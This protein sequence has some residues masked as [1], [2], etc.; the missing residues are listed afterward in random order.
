MRKSK[1]SIAQL[2]IQ[3]GKKGLLVIAIDFSSIIDF[4]KR[5]FIEIR[6]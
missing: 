6:R 2:N 3:M 1:R 5:I 4:F